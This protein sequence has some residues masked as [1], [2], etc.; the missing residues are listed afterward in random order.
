MKLE[1]F[2]KSF[3]LGKLPARQDSVLFKLS[4]YQTPIPVP[5]SVMRQNL[6]TDWQ[7]FLGNDKVGCCV[8]AGAAHESILWNTESKKTVL[9][10]PENVISDYSAITGYNPKDPSTDKGTDMQL[11][12]SYRRKTGIIDK[13]G[14]RHRIL[15]YL[16]VK[17]VKQEIQESI[18]LFSGTGIGLIFP[19][20]AMDQFSAN[21]PWTVVNGSKIVGGHYVACVG[22]DSNYVY[23]ITWGRVQKMSWG[24]V[25]K[26]SDEIIT[27]LSTEMLKDGKSIDGF[28]LVQLQDSLSKL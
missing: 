10:T 25:L 21:K 7:G 12:A 4:L 22:F 17:P 18:Y 20:S 23:C 5:K 6:V 19:Q 2:E 11:A 28:N 15:A 24:F 13:N 1:D 14:I 26:Y 9:Y 16:S 27:Y 3:K 8:I